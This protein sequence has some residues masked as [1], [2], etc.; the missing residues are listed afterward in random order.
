[1]QGQ[2]G[3]SRKTEEEKKEERKCGGC[4]KGLIRFSDAGVPKDRQNLS[5]FSPLDFV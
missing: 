4:R 3:G 5:G 2:E 1:M